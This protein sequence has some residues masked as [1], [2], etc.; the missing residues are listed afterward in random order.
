MDETLHPDWIDAMI[1]IDNE[2]YNKNYINTGNCTDKNQYED[3]T[4]IC[5]QFDNIS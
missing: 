2:Q 3:S 5:K 4:I 1:L